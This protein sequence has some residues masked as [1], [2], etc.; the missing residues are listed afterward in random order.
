[1]TG[2]AKP[3]LMVV[4]TVPPDLRTAL[5]ERCDLADYAADSAGRF[6][7]APTYGIA[8]TTSMRG[9]DAPLFEALPDLRLV[10]CN[11][12]GLERIDLGEAHRRGVAVC[13]TPDELAQDVAECAIALTYAIMRRVV[14]AD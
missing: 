7:L 12:A 11:G 3:K 5:A 2:Q 1:M 6:P 4:T 9:F 10:V 8:A 13:H 14:E